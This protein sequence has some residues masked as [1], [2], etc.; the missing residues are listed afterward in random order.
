MAGSMTRTLN[1]RRL[2]ARPIHP[3]DWP[4]IHAIQSDP[5]HGY[6]VRGPF[7]PAS[8]DRSQR[9][10]RKLSSAWE[11]GYGPFVWHLNGEPIGYAGLRLTRLLGSNA[12]EALWGF[13]ARAHHQGYANEAM[14]AVLRKARPNVEEVMSW[15]LPENIPSRSLMERLGFRYQ[16]DRMYANLRHVVYR[17]EP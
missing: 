3:E 4:L 13:V 11:A 7:A 8:P 12:A 15:T 14:Q 16:H 10:A 5:E 9:I 17:L 6:W 2:T 1:T